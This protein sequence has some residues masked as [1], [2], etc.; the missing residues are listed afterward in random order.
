MLSCRTKLEKFLCLKKRG[1]MFWLNCSWLGTGRGQLCGSD[2][3]LACCRLAKRCKKG[4][5]EGGDSTNKEEKGSLRKESPF[6]DQ[7]INL[8]V[9][10]SETMLKSFVRKAGTRVT[11]PSSPTLRP[12][13]LMPVF[14]CPPCCACAC[15]C[16][17]ACTCATTAPGAEG[18]RMYVMSEIA[19]PSA[20]R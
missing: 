10:W 13:R 7:Y 16:P 4:Q 19:R 6:G 20:A 17:C 18:V 5:G 14:G 2:S 12:F 8:S 1:R 3:P 15:A 11:S 9:S